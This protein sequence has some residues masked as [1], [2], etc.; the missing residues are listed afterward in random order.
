[1]DTIT[2][3]SVGDLAT[4]IPTFERSLRAANKSPKTIQVYGE[5]ARQLL[6]FLRQQGMPTEVAKLGREHVEAFIE[7]LVATRAPATASN[8][9]RALMALFNFAV[10]FG[11][12][13]D[14]PMR[15]M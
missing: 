12:I 10:D 11:E 14:S 1:M 5:A 4:L 13:T 8:R 9:Y 2:A 6:G 3:A 7:H 15:K